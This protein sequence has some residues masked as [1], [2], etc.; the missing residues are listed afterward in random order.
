LDFVVSLRQGEES[1]AAATLGV[2]LVVAGVAFAVGLEKKLKMLCC[3]PVDA[4]VDFFAADGVFAG[5]CVGRDDFPII[6]TSKTFKS[7]GSDSKGI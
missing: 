5:V 4:E 7:N 3:F 1:G 2:V 6:F